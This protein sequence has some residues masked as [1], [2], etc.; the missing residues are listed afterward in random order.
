MPDGRTAKVSHPAWG[1]AVEG[2]GHRLEFILTTV[3][4]PRDELRLTAVDVR[5]CIDGRPAAEAR[6]TSGLSF[7]DG[8]NSFR[9]RRD[10]GSTLCLAETVSIILFSRSTL[11]S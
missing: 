5:V 10:G 2:A 1:V 11:L 4:D 3:D 8:E 9:L 7:F 6:I